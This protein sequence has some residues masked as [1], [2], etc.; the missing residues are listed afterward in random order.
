M[1]IFDY[2]EDD[3]QVLEGLE[4]VRKR[5]GMYIG[6]TGIRGL[7]HC[8]WEIL[9]NSIDEWLAGVCQ[10]IIVT[11]HKDWSFSVEDDGRGMPYK[12]QTKKNISAERLIFTVLHAGSKFDNKAYKVAG[13]LHGVGASVV[14][15]LSKYLKVEIFRD[16]LYFA[17]EYK[18]GGNPVTKLV[19]GELVPIKKTSK[20]G[21]RVTFVPDDS[22]FETTKF[23]SDIIK[24]KLQEFAY[25]CKGLTIKYI[26]E[27]ENEN[28][29]FYEEE[30][31]VGFIKELNKLKSPIHDDVIYLSGSN[32]DIEVEIAFQYTRD[33]NETILSF[34]NNISTTEGGNHV[35]GFKNALTRVINQYARELSILKE[36]DK[37]FEGNDIRS[38]LTAII[39]VKHPEPQFEG[40]T[41]TKLGNPDLRSVVDEVFNIQGQVYFDKNLEVLKIIIDNALKAYRLKQIE[42][43]ARTDFFNKS[44][45][46]TLNSKLADCQEKNPQLTEIYLVEGDSA[47]GSAKQGRNRKYQAVLPLKG[48]VLNV[49]KAR[50]DKILSS[51]QIRFMITAFGC[52]FGEGYGDD[53]DISKMRYGKIIIL[54]DAD[55][56]GSHIRTLILTFF[57]RYMPELIHGGYVFIGMPPLYK[58][59]KKDNRSFTDKEAQE[60]EKLLGRK[61]LQKDGSKEKN[62]SFI[63]LYNDREL[64]LYN[65]KISKDYGLQR[66]KGLGEMNP[67]QLWETT[68]NP[69][70]RYLKEVFIEDAA[71]ADEI[72]TILMGDNVPPRKEFIYNE[73]QNANLDF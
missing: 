14:N 21:T 17:D 61:A 53:F 13:G 43:K 48:K 23:R 26:D 58:L 72:T 70:V 3:I 20:R 47:G 34:C 16:G 46:L 50:L 31:I 24:K 2:S 40:Q 60:L 30:G 22:I 66:Y 4:P 42:E 28:I 73:A 71:Q 8:A 19:N 63:Y 69:E 38:G 44:N 10:N 5:P 32:G 41:K 18:D 35:S 36:K 52:G 37:N 12:K 49:E 55:V 54:T 7:H 62:R 65:K 67:E 9:N 64:E 15:A 25:L 29:V 59:T 56:D 6:N 27:I 51:E 33:F 1:D 57:Y 39:L 45:R 68:L 11:L